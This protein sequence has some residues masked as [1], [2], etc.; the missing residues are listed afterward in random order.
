MLRHI[1]SG[2]HYAISMGAGMD[3]TYAGG[4]VLTHGAADAT[5]ERH[6]EQQKS[7][8]SLLLLLLLLLPLLSSPLNA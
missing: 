7:D 2:S 5:A 6:Y 8:S 1:R 3:V 4:L